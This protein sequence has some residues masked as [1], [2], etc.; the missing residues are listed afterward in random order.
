MKIANPVYNGIFNYLMDD[1]QAAK[2]VLSILIDKKIISVER[3]P[4]DNVSLDF[5][6]GIQ[7]EEMNLEKD[8]RRFPTHEDAGNCT[9]HYY[10]L[11]IEKKPQ[12]H[13]EII[14]ELQKFKSIHSINHVKNY[15]SYTANTERYIK[16]NKDFY[17]CTIPIYSV[18][19]LPEVI[20]SE[21]VLA[22]K[23]V[24]QYTNAIKN[25]VIDEEKIPYYMKPPVEEIY[26][27]QPTADYKED[28]NKKVQKF[29]GLFKYGVQDNAL[30]PIIEISDTFND[31]IIMSIVER[32]HTATLDK[33][34]MESIQTE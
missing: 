15:I 25:T 19:I 27:F 23:I 6:L 22:C 26:I 4:A 7:K 12:K 14:L 32:L 13:K 29:L 30:N 24:T 3:V 17:K 20:S 21:Q 16:V 28:S 5:T 31:E 11:I 8:K 1:E 2:N 34:L 10:K 9:S 18:Y 33:S